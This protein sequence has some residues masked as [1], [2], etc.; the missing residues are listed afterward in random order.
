M[1]VAKVC[2]NSKKCNTPEL[3]IAFFKTAD[4]ALGV[5]RLEKSSTI[6]FALMPFGHHKRL[7]SCL[8]LSLNCKDLSLFRQNGEFESTH[9][10]GLK[11]V[12][13]P[14]ILRLAI[15][16]RHGN[17]QSCNCLICKE[18][19]SK[20]PLILSFLQQMQWRISIY[21][22]QSFGYNLCQS[23][24]YKKIRDFCIAHKCTPENRCSGVTVCYFVF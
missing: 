20:I 13:I 8:V 16:A 17:L 5:F 12:K 24:S 1:S 6:F 11:S 22:P 21:K 7:F 15:F 19:D 23:K 14:Q 18:N 9:P 10:G 3:L 4:F 2:E